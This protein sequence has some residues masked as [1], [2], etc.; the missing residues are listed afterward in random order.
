MLTGYR[1]AHEE[2]FINIDDDLQNPPEEALRMLEHARMQ[3][4]DVLYENYIVKKKNLFR[5]AG[6][7]FA[8]L[9]ARLL[10]DLPDSHYLSSCRCVSRLSGEHIAVNSS[11][12]IYI[13]MCAMIHEVPGAA[14]TIS[15]V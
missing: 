14:A 3:E 10:L 7:G 11:P 15:A 4:L 2:Y 12:Y 5:N 9:T 6:S 1:H 8:N 13:W